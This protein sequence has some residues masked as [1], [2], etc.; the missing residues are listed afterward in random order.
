MES[1]IAADGRQD[2]TMMPFNQMR[3]EEHLTIVHTKGYVRH[4][5]CIDKTSPT[6]ASKIISV[7]DDTDSRNTLKCLAMDGT[8]VNSGWKTGAIRRVEENLGRS[9]LWII[10]ILH[11]NERPFL[12]YFKYCDASGKKKAK[13]K[14]PS[15]DGK[16]GKLFKN[17]L[18][19]KP[20]VKFKAIQGKVKVY[21]VKVRGLT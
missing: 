10:C 5:T 14:S 19:L 15:Y 16:I 17:K 12:Q 1:I 7:I 11:T 18:D 6:V 3:P 13:T 4:N 2:I 9:L 21:E 20:I 8:N